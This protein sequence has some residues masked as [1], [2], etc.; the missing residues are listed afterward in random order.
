MSFSHTYKVLFRVPARALRIVLLRSAPH[1]SAGGHFSPTCK[2]REDVPG[3]CLSEKCLH[4]FKGIAT[5]YQL[6]P[7]KHFI[8]VP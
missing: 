2:I 8:T 7:G 5:R 6:L 1:A 3:F 4:C